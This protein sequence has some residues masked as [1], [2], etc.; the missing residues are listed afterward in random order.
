[1]IVL[2]WLKVFAGILFSSETWYRTLLLP[3]EEICRK[4]SSR[5]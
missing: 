5:C 4:L 1:M 3:S 2:D